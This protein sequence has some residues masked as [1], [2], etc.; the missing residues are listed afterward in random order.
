ML[1]FRLPL[2]GFRPIKDRKRRTAGAEA[3]LTGL[4]V[5]TR[6]QPGAGWGLSTASIIFDK[7]S[8]HSARSCTR[9]LE[10]W[11]LVHTCLYSHL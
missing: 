9:S 10:L 4:A 1:A 5:R 3:F 11:S 2:A 7:S 6:A 8:H